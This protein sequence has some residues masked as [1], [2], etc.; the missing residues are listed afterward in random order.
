MQVSVGLVLSTMH[1]T[2]TVF[3][4]ILLL[5]GSEL[6]LNL[7]EVIM[8]FREEVYEKRISCAYFLYSYLELSQVEKVKKF[9]ATQVN[10]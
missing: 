9:N 8:I 10:F 1:C 3:L 6:N 2:L 5:K 4:K 7:S